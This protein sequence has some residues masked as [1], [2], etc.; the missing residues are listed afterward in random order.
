METSS[1]EIKEMAWFDYHQ[2]PDGL[3]LKIKT[4]AAIWIKFRIEKYISSFNIFC[5]HT[6]LKITLLW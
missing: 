5:Y 1:P 2:L 6:R 4:F 3:G